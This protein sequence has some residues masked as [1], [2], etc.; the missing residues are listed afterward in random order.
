M[1]DD[2]AE[3]SARFTREVSRSI[4]QRIER[5][6]RLGELA[7]SLH[8]GDQLI[9]HAHPYAIVAR[10]R[11]QGLDQTVGIRTPAPMSIGGKPIVQ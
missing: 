1:R 7:R 2:S 4:R 11:H 6:Q 5:P 3:G 8:L 9:R 10:E